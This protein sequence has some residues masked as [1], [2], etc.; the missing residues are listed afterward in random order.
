LDVGS[1]LRMLASFRAREARVMPAAARTPQ[2]GCGRQR[3][4]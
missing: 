1:P 3:E 4:Q 2:P